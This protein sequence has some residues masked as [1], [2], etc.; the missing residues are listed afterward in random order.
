MISPLNKC[1]LCKYIFRLAVK[2]RDLAAHFLAAGFRVHDYRKM[3]AG[4]ERNDR[5]NGESKHD[6]GQISDDRVLTI[7]HERQILA[8][9]CHE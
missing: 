5:K 2:L 8:V 7:S 1:T 4:D 3:Q 6:P 9:A